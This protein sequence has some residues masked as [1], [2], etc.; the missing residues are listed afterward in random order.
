MDDE[1]DVVETPEVEEKP[2]TELDDAALD[3]ALDVADKE[4]GTPEIEQEK[5]EGG[6][7]KP[8]LEE[9]ESE[10]SA[11]EKAAK[12]IK[13]KE[14]FIQ[15]Q[16]AELGE[17]RK[18]AE[19]LRLQLE[20]VNKDDLNDRY[21]EDPAAAVNEV[22]AIRAKE[23][24]LQ[25]LEYRAAV[26]QNESNTKQ[27]VP[28]F[29][30]VIDD[31]VEVLKE[32]KIDDTAIR[33]FRSNPYKLPPAVLVN[34]AT[35]AKLSKENKAL[36]AEIE[37]LRKKPEEALKKVESAARQAITGGTGKAGQGKIDAK[38]T[39]QMSA[40]ELDDLLNSPD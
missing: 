3:A 1:K 12:Q 28:D 25:D 34:L 35:S 9:G 11:E 13:D 36:K 19:A 10:P 39:H 40:A 27:F 15:R 8:D 21:Y 6:E 20:G 26:K 38:Q 4:E 14:E 33:D 5:E 17:L 2:L 37:T 29:D 16:A 32:Q 24:E 30:E 7:V 31:M 22:L 23:A 18:Q